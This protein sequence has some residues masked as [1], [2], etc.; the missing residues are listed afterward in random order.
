MFST[1]PHR[2][3]AHR[4]ECII[5]S[6]RGPV[7]Y[8]LEQGEYRMRLGSGGLV[9]ALLCATQ[10]RT[11][12]WIAFTMTQADRQGVLED[13]PEQDVLPPALAGVTLRHLSI[14]EETYRRYYANIS[15]QVLWFAQHTMLDVAT[16][17][18]FSQQTRT[19]WDE[20]YRPANEAIANAII[21]ELETWGT[22]IPVL[23]QDYQ[24]YLVAE[25]VRARFPSAR[26]GH[27]IYIPWPDA[28]Y[29]A[30]LPTYMAHQIYHSML[31]ND[32]IGFQTTNDARNFL[33]GAQR[34]LPGAHVDWHDADSKQPATV[35]WQGRRINIHLY[36]AVLS[37][38][39]LYTLTQSQ[40]AQAEIQALDADLQLSQDRK[41]IVRV[42]RIEPT[43][44]ILRGFQ[45]Y[46]QLLQEHPEF[47]GKVTFL[48]L[49]IPSRE[50]VASY[51]HYERMVR[52]CITRINERYGRADWQPIVARFGNNR[53]RAL[54]S[55]QYY[56]VL[57]VNP[58][59]D[60]MNLVVKEG[61]L[62][63]QRSGVIILSRT[64]GAH[65][66]LGEQV[67]S[68]APLALDE[69][70]RALHHALTMSSEERTRRAHKIRAILT[71]EDAVRWFG[72]QIKSLTAN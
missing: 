56:D 69:T 33:A 14:P 11:M 51:V 45:A 43:K 7:E 12:T 61:G 46:E 48:A 59:I 17:T 39:Y 50:N 27:V 58:V 42:D 15:N 70:T 28:R 19:D 24:L 22:D 40:E 34:F 3:T 31:M 47:Q 41:L 2:Q 32:F 38:H 10:D 64:V 26:L 53:V 20:G 21:H 36:P 68:I 13:L 23:I 1:T 71:E 63:N 66:T 55:M 49:L 25:Q 57:L 37:A 18:E 35:Y 62:L 54:V 8:H 30:M 16:G 67:V 44:N 52:A 29:L 6:N 4:P 72:R 9:T 60:G 65:D 5:A